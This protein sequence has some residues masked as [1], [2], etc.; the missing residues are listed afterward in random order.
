MNFINFSKQTYKVVGL[1]FISLLF[2]L[3][4]NRGLPIL[5][6]SSTFS[7]RWVSLSLIIIYTISLTWSVWT[8]NWLQ[9]H[10]IINFVKTYLVNL[11]LLAYFTTI[12]NK[13][14]FNLSIFGKTIDIHT[15]WSILLFL[16]I[17]LWKHYYVFIRPTAKQLLLNI[18]V[19]IINLLFFSLISLFQV[20]RT[21]AR[22][23]ENS[24]LT[25]VVTQNSILFLAFNLLIITTLLI[26]EISQYNLKK[27]IY[28]ILLILLILLEFVFLIGVEPITL[29]QNSNHTYWHK[30]LLMT[31][32]WSFVY[33]NLRRLLK[34]D[35]QQVYLSKLS[36][37]NFYH[38]ILFIIIIILT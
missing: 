34:P 10:K 8:E 29:I 13:L 36:F 7:Q 2:M 24:F 38:A 22:T 28:W 3:T 12:D 26:I 27:N 31:I 18:E 11:V 6:L 5:I 21:A 25:I 32:V 20:D 4:I 33:Q 19:F 14:L 9:K 1:T 30:A 23:F 37:S 16:F 15:G 35:P 17:I